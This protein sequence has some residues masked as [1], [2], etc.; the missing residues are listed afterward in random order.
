G[1]RTARLANELDRLALWAGPEGRVGLTDLESM[2]ADTSEEATWTLSDAIVEGD[3][4]V[5]MAAAERLRGQGETVTG[6]IWQGAKRVRAAAEARAQ[7]D[8]GRPAKEVE[9]ALGMHPY[10]A[11]ML[12]RKV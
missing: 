5:A 7:L 11:R 2:I 8:A 6:L 9:G 1:P 4:A 12:L 3:A 10:A